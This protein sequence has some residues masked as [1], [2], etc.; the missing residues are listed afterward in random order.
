MHQL[1]RAVA[2]REA[3]SGL[4]HAAHADNGLFRMEWCGD[5]ASVRS[6]TFVPLR[7]WS[8]YGQQLGNDLVCDKNTRRVEHGWPR[9]NGRFLDKKCDVLLG[10]ETMAG[11]ASSTRPVLVTGSRTYITPSSTYQNRQKVR[12]LWRCTSNPLVILSTESTSPT[13][14]H[15]PGCPHRFPFVLLL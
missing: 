9:R 5:R 13:N 1:R 14:T 15:V 11:L 2:G 8:G 12:D 10:S 7:L 6:A 3:S 4:R